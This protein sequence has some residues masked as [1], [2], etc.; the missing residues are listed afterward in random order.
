MIMHPLLL[1]VADSLT[2]TSFVTID[3]GRKALATHRAERLIG[4]CRP[5]YR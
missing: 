5:P 1:P 4:Y 2:T 3:A